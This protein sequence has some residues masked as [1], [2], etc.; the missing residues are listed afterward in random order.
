MENDVTED[1]QPKLIP[2]EPICELIDPRLAKELGGETDA[3]EQPTYLI[4]P[5]I[6][7]ATYE[8]RHNLIC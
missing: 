1:F 8:K 7:M 2:L 6:Q 4:L 3:E 5:K